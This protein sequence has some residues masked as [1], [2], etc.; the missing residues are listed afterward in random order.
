MTV[1]TNPIMR[2][3]AYTHLNGPRREICEVVSKLAT[4]MD[5][6]LPDGVE[7][8]AGLRKLLEAKDC[9]VRAVLT[10]ETPE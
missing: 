1:N 5:E 10:R 4:H 8:S 3:F 7:K 6:Y 9:F 2:F